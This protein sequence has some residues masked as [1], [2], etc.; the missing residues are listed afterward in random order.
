MTGKRIAPR[1]L[2]PEVFSE[3]PIREYTEKEKQKELEEIKKQ[4]GLTN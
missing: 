4:V 2:L 3:M 1:T